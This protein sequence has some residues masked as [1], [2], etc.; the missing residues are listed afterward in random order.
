VFPNG[1]GFLPGADQ[2]VEKSLCFGKSIGDNQK[3]NKRGKNVE[4]IAH[5]DSI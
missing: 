3:F 5:N 1:D 2:L 4:T